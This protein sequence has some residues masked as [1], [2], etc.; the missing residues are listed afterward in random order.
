M[1]RT[2]IMAGGG[3]QMFEDRRDAGRQLAARLARYRSDDLVVLGVQP[4]GIVVGREVARA[5]H[6]PLDVVVV[7]KLRT[8]RPPG[9]AIGAIAGGTVPEVVLD[10]GVITTLR[11]SADYVHDEVQVQ[12]CEIRLREA[13]LREGRRALPLADRTVI[14]VDDAVVTGTTVRSSLAA[15]RRNG[16]RRLVL[17]VPVAPADVVLAFRSLADRVVC[18]STP[19]RF[20]G[21]RAFYHDFEGVPDGHVVTLLAEARMAH[22]IPGVVTS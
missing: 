17:A 2:L 1:R 6:A 8:P 21:V 9:P 5:L 22:G 12:L 11:V 13:L 14:V 10:Q 3:H 16:P 19:Q 20:D 18:L 15:I 7:R 4:G